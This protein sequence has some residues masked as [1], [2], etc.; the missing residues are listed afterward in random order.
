MDLSQSIAQIT[1]ISMRRIGR[2]LRLT[3]GLSFNVL[4]ADRLRGRWCCMIEILPV[5]PAYFPVV[6][7]LASDGRGKHT[8]GINSHYRS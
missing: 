4:S 8:F 5:S 7:V 2:R 6:F 3:K 1:L